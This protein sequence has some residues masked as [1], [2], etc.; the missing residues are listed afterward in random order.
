MAAAIGDSIQ[1]HPLLRLSIS[2]ICGIGLADVLYPHVCSLAEWGM[3]GALLS[4]IVMGVAWAR[5]QGVAFGVSALALFLSLGVWNYSAVRYG[6]AQT[7]PEGKRV[8]EALVLSEPRARQRSTL[9]EV[10]VTAVCDSM[11]WHRVGQKVYA[12]ME[13]CDEAAALRVGETLCFKGEVRPPR[14]FSDSLTFDYARY[15]TLRGVSGTVYLPRERWSRVGE[16]TLSLRD[17]LLRLR[18]RLAERHMAVAFEGDVLGVLSAL[19]LGDK[20]GLSDE[21][22]SIYSDAGVAHVLALSGL[23]VGIIYGMLSFL[24]RRVIRRRRLRWLPEVLTVG[25][26]WAFALMVGMSASVVRAV[27]MCTLFAA[28]RW[29]SDGTTSSLH[30]LSLT[31][32]AMLLVRPLYLFDVGFQLS[33]MA[34]ASIVCLEPYLEALVRKQT[35]HPVMAYLVG[36]VCMSTAAQLGTF[37]LVLHHFGSFPAYFLLTNLLAIPLLFLLLLLMLVWWGLT[38]VGLASLAQLLGT[39][40][41]HLV[42]VF[43]GCLHHIGQWPGAVVHVEGYPAPAVLFTYLF[44]LFTGLFFIHKWPRGLVYAMASLLGLLLTILF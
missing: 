16:R 27:A 33:F 30:V 42:G 29:L 13:P 28:A 25:V 7:W 26:L 1:R 4:L 24:L 31:A 38:L 39:L 23:H 21:V 8:Y 5:R 22:R 12:Y 15:L 11:G 32:L 40:L 41:Q 17:R 10:R 9:C 19:T 37:P 2:Y 14:N 20:R 36:I 6:H 44:I 3:W 35:L 34:M 18:S 43:H